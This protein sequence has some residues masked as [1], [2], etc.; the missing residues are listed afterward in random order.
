MATLILF[1][2]QDQSGASVSLRLMSMEKEAFFPSKSEDAC[3][4][5]ME[6]QGGVLLGSVCVCLVWGSVGGLFE[7]CVR[8]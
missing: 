5:P 2:K 3:T 4:E 1:D 7:N 8:A 6:L